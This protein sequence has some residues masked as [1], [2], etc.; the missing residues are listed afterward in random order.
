VRL[1]LNGFAEQILPLIEAGTGDQ[2][3]PRNQP[4][5]SRPP[6]ALDASSGQGLPRTR[7]P[8][9]ERTQVV[10]RHPSGQGRWRFEWW[11]R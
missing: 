10:G 5:C 11:F 6:G 4:P 1:D 7:R 3:P 8:R 2:E 9:F